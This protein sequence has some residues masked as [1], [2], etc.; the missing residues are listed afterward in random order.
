MMGWGGLL[1][2]P[3]DFEG[4]TPYTWRGIGGAHWGSWVESYWS[5]SYWLP[6]PGICHLHGQLEGQGCLAR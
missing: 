4:P 6:S 3:R 1:W 5:P 2:L